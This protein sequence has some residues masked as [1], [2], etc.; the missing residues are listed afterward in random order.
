MGRR[1]I[2]R[3]TTHNQTDR[4]QNQ[5]CDSVRAAPADDP[6]IHWTPCRLRMCGPTKKAPASPAETGGIEDCRRRRRPATGTTVNRSEPAATLETPA[7]GRT[8][9]VLWGFRSPPEK[10]PL[11]PRRFRWPDGG[12]NRRGPPDGL[13]S[14]KF[15]L[16]DIGESRSSPYGG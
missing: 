2:E 15:T 5:P 3:P 14:G 7:P 13:T 8:S 1:F 11:P 4:R 12:S 10:P 9:A 6:A 16:S